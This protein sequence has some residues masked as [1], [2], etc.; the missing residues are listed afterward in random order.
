MREATSTTVPSDLTQ[1]WSFIQIIFKFI[2]KNN[3]YNYLSKRKY[4]PIFFDHIQQ[5]T[6]RNEQ[7][8]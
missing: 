1:N 5:F 8:F 7:S 6:I 3:T 2:L 4:F